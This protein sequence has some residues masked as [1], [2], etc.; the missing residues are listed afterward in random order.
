[1]NRTAFAQPPFAHLTAEDQDAS[2][3][4]F[5]A[6]DHLQVRQVVAMV[7][8]CDGHEVVEAAD[9]REL[10]EGIASILTKGGACEYDLIVAEQRLP[11]ILGL[12]VLAALRSAN[13]LT[14]FVLMTA[15]ADVKAQ[16]ASLGAVILD[17][18]FNVQAIRSA[19]RLST[20]LGSTLA[21]R[22]D[23]L[24]RGRSIVPR[25]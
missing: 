10:L 15:D 20:N 19:V 7:L 9:G 24:A 8:R 2:L 13:D 6:E 21:L 18:P 22:G 4:I 17:H 11:G 23:G 14:P 1:M 5:L 16:A 25:R 3:R 12:S